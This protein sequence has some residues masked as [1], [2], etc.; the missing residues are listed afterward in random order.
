MWTNQKA[1]IALLPRTHRYVLGFVVNSVK[2]IVITN[3][4]VYRSVCDKKIMQRRKKML[5]LLYHNGSVACWS[6]APA[7]ASYET[8]ICWFFHW[9]S[10]TGPSLHCVVLCFLWYPVKLVRPNNT[11]ITFTDCRLMLMLVMILMI[12]LTINRT[13]AELCHVSWGMYNRLNT[14]HVIWLCGFILNK[15][16]TMCAMLCQSLTSVFKIIYKVA[17]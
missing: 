16:F 7:M 9:P 11:T 14:L 17:D 15:V 4:Q 3:G 8:C 2:S 10:S 13:L 12:P 1:M 6:Y 5:Q